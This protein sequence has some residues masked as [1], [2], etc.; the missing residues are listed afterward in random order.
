MRIFS[1]ILQSEKFDPQAKYI[2]KYLPELEF[3]SLK[4]IHNPLKGNLKYTRMIVD[5]SVAQRE[6]REAYKSDDYLK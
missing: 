6:A 2:K 4:D 3:E 1:P 5:H